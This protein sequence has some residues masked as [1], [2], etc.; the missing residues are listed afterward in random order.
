M[1]RASAIKWI[2]MHNFPKTAMFFEKGS[3]FPSKLLSKVPLED[4]KLP[5]DWHITPKGNLVRH[6][7]QSW[8]PIEPR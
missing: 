8:I 1:D 2:Y 6:N 4:L 7:P 5:N 3:K